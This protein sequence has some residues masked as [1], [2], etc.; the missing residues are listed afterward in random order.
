MNIINTDR[1]TGQTFGLLVLGDITSVDS[2]YNY[3]IK[4]T[5]SCG[6]KKE[7]WLKAITRGATKSCGCLRKEVTTNKNIKHGLSKVPE[8][9]VWKGIKARCFNKNEKAY[10]FYG[11]RGISMC[12]EWLSDF[13]KFYDDMGKRPS[14][15]HS[16]DRIN[17]NGNYEPDN[18]RWST[19]KE[20]ANNRRRR[21]KVTPELTKA[22]KDLKEV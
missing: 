9:T 17:N 22:L 6:S 5:C 2:H 10:R 18:C 4:A 15:K 7:Y 14:K 16:I 20:Q 11:A 8:Y 1:Y 13:T 21:R 12:N 19:M 3:K